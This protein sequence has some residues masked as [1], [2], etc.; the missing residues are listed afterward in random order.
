MAL[1][2]S[3]ITKPD[4]LVVGRLYLY[5]Q[6]GKLKRG[7]CKAITHNNV[8][9]TDNTWLYDDDVNFISS[10]YPKTEYSFIAEY[11][12]SL[13]YKYDKLLKRQEKERQ[14]LLKGEYIEVDEE[15]KTKKSIWK[16]LFKRKQ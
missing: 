5:L 13:Y 3:R 16:Y 12:A 14:S 15:V 9:F 8:T 1:A 10:H 7:Y 11:S 4:Q 2:I 6:Y